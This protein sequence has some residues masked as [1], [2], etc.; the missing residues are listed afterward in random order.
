M[1]DELEAR[2]LE[3]GDDAD[4][5]VYGDWLEQHGDPRGKLIALQRAG[6]DAE[7][8]QLVAEHG[9][10]FGTPV[11]A[12]VTWRLG[13]WDTIRLR[14]TNVDLAA[15]LALPS[16]RLVR[17]V[18]IDHPT[19][20]IGFFHATLSRSPHIADSSTV[21]ALARLLRT[22]RDGLAWQPALAT[23]RRLRL[24]CTDV[25]I[26]ERRLWEHD[27][28]TLA[29][30]HGL[31][32]LYLHAETVRPESIAREAFLAL[33]PLADSLVSLSAMQC[34]TFD[35]AILE[36]VATFT[37][38]EELRAY[39][40]AITSDGIALLARLPRLRSL[41]VC[42]CRNANDTMA[43]VIGRLPSIETVAIS[44]TRMTSWGVKAI[45]RSR[46]IQKIVLDDRQ[47]PDEI[48]SVLGIELEE[49]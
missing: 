4:Y 36:M 41:D 1:N 32:S 33:A 30:I 11:E 44:G 26:S 31:T 29:D 39:A 43:E 27:G 34:S 3:S 21:D 14:D 12:V 10:L 35:D 7:W 38:L 49:R 15:I 25:T 23:L 45:G 16:A 18:T 19:D 40:T 5:A 13:F 6:L 22:D 24:G 42:D 48:E 28:R 2:I 46:T 20:T 9:E 47:F 17:E 37:H 8:R